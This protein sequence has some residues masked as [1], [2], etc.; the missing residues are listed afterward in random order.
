M[1]EKEQAQTHE[2]DRDHEPQGQE[3]EEIP[4]QNQESEGG[5]KDARHRPRVLGGQG[6]LARLP[7]FLRLLGKGD[8]Q[9]RVDDEADSPQQGSGDEAE[10]DPYRIDLHV[11]GE[12]AA[13]TGDNPIIDG[14]LQ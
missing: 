12:P 7:L 5:E 9:E 3:R 6:G 14:P 2:E 13:H 11:I 10:P 8:P 1:E 4:E